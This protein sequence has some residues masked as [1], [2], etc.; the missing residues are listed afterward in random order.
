MFVF[1]HRT[2]I[3]MTRWRYYGIRKGIPHIARNYVLVYPSY[4]LRPK[5]LRENE[6]LGIGTNN[7]TRL[8]Y[9][10]NN[11]AYVNSWSLRAVY[12]KGSGTEYWLTCSGITCVQVTAYW[13]FLPQKHPTI[14]LRRLNRV[15]KIKTFIGDFN[16]EIGQKILY[17]PTVEK[18]TK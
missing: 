15:I 11:T 5:L 6:L 3:I 12:Y 10:S 2:N 16:A 13:S 1:A 18:D 8:V 9:I 4:S 7:V 14:Y 17:R